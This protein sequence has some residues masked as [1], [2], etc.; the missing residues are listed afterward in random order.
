MAQATPTLK[1][2]TQKVVRS[3]VMPLAR[4]YQADHMFVV[5]RVHGMISTDTMDAQCNSIHAEKYLQ[6]FGNKEFFVEAY[7]IKRKADC[8][9]GLETFVHEYGKMERLIYDGAPE[10]IGRKTEFQRIIRKYDIR[11]HRAESGRSN[12]NPV[13]VCIREL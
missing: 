11:G 10:K 12:Q 1:S 9:E 3:A 8:H 6:V 4:R 7:T 5:R 2:T 13:E